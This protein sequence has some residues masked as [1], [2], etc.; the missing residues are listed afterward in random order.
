MKN[1]TTTGGFW[2]FADAIF[3]HLRMEKEFNSR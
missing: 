3:P 1:K 2:N